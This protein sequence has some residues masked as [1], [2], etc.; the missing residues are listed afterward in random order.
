MQSRLV[1]EGSN[2]HRPTVFSMVYGQAAEPIR[3]AVIQ[4]TFYVDFVDLS[5]CL[6]FSAGLVLAR[7]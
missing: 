1:A 2:E 5:Q 4:V 3:P 7:S 6:K